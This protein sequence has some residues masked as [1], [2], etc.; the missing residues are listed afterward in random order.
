MFCFGISGPTRGGGFKWIWTNVN[1]T[2]VS[3]G[4]VYY[5][6]IIC[7]DYTLEHTSMWSSLIFNKVVRSITVQKKIIGKRVDFSALLMVNLLI[8]ERIVRN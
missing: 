2:F 5:Y 8:I 4:I 3:M 1:I 6:I 7:N